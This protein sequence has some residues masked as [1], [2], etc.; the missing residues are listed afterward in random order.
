MKIE[1]LELTLLSKEEIWGDKNGEGQL[2]V[3]KKYGTISAITDLVILTGGYYEAFC[4][5]MSPDDTTLRGSTGW[6]YTKSPNGRGNVHCIY[7][8]GTNVWSYC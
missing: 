5:Y 4:R 3:I 2:D 6:S 8:N 7:E 1:D